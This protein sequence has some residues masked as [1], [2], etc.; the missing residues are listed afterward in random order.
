MPVVVV[1]FW[2]VVVEGL[3]CLQGEELLKQF[4]R[5]DRAAA[6]I[7]SSVHLEE[8]CL[9]GCPIERGFIEG[10]VRAFPLVHVHQ[11]KRGTLPSSTW[12]WDESVHA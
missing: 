5:R 11:N 4:W 8:L 3:V 10:L 9:C 6:A 2:L 12:V 7:G 1:V